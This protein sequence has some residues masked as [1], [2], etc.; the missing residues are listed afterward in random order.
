MKAYLG[1]ELPKE[2]QQSDWSGELSQSQLRYA[3][4]DAAILL[5]LR[6]ALKK[7]LIQAKLV[8]VATLEFDCIVA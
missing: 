2:E 1:E 3:A 5:P 7:Q 6:D 4:N 8:E